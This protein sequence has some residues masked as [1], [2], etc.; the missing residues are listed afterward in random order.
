MMFRVP[1]WWSVRLDRAVTPDRVIVVV[2]AV[3]V[4]L[5]HRE[6]ASSPWAD[7][8]ALAGEPVWFQLAA[9]LMHAAVSG[10]VSMAS[11][12]T[13][14]LDPLTPWS[15][16][17]DVRGLAAC[18][19]GLAAA[20]L[21]LLLRFWL[22]PRTIAALLACVPAAGTTLPVSIPLTVT[23]TL[24]LLLGVLVLFSL[25]LVFTRGPRLVPALAGLTLVGTINHESFL[26]FA[27][28]AWS[29]VVWQDRER[30]GRSA[31]IA[32]AALIVSL[33]ASAAVL[34]LNAQPWRR[35]HPILS[36]AGLEP[37]GTLALA[38]PLVTGRFSPGVQPSAG[39]E[40][41]WRIE[42]ALPLPVMLL[43]PLAICAWVRRD[44]RQ[45][46]VVAIAAA[47]V[48]SLWVSSTWVPDPTVAGAIVTAAG[49]LAA[50]FGL[51]WVAGQQVRGA[52]ALAVATAAFAAC[53]GFVDRSRLAERPDAMVL[54]AFTA[55]IRPSVEPGLW[56]SERIAVDR[57]FLLDP[58]FPP[59]MPAAAAALGRLRDDTPCV[60]LPEARAALARQGYDTAAF[61]VAFPSAGAFMSA[62]RAGD[63]VA[64]AVRDDSRRTEPFSREMLQFFHADRPAEPLDRVALL[65]PANLRGTPAA[66]VERDRVD[67][68]F[69]QRIGVGAPPVPVR[70]AI[71]TEPGARI[72]VNT[73]SIEDVPRGAVLVVFNPWTGERESWVLGASD[74]EAV[75]PVIRDPRLQPGYLLTGSRVQSTLN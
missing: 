75:R 39:G 13:A 44:A 70:V 48:V 6:A 24:H 35:S 66:A 33:G 37:P 41:W 49:L 63:W 40:T 52:A 73:V 5:A 71:E 2:L 53:H 50:G 8:R 68:R 18:L 54:Q 62:R 17:G 16:A 69:G 74:D 19:G 32:A 27:A 43:V 23:H 67:L 29:A 55:A 1:R 59:R 10:A 28:V 15:W 12:M 72:A 30:R 51:S 42:A 4:G 25:S 38:I 3:L 22:V 60:A 46:V 65:G 56:V 34:Q 20:F 64:L 47:G 7:D 14:L 57:S 45:T 11:G 31:A 61:E 21:Y 58:R 9:P 26:P 36:G